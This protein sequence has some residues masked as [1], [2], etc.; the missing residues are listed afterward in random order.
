MLSAKDMIIKRIERGDEVDV[1]DLFNLLVA[2]VR[3]M[4]ASGDYEIK[5]SSPLPAENHDGDR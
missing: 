5:A 3:K 4:I 2:E 1:V